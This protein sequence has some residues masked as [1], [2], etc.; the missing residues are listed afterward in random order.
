MNKYGFD[1]RRARIES[2]IQKTVSNVLLRCNYID[3]GL[4][5]LNHVF[6]NKSRSHA[7]LYVS[8]LRS[9]IPNHLAFEKLLGYRFSIFHE[10]T[11][12]LRYIS[13]KIPQFVFLLDNS[14]TEQNRIDKILKSL[15]HSS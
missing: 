14:Q 2:L 6:I 5:L 4:I 12:R 7:W 10:I 15:H 13:R 1:R 9:P 11:T 8:F 3:V